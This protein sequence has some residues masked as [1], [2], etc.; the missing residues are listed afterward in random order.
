MNTR[1]RYKKTSK[2]GVLES[3]QTLTSQSTGAKYKVFVDLNECQYVIKNLSG[4]GN[5]YGGDTANC[6]HVL[7][8][9]VRRHLKKLGVKFKVET[10]LI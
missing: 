3:V 2:D 8:R 6:R 4:R 5:F 9:Q 7:Y 1:I 10:R